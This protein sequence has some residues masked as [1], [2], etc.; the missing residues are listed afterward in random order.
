MCLLSR[1]DSFALAIEVE[2]VPPSSSLRSW[3]PV[4]KMGDTREGVTVENERVCE[5]GDC[6]P[7]EGVRGERD[8][9]TSEPP[10]GTGR[11]VDVSCSRRDLFSSM[12]SLFAAW[13][14]LYFAP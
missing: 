9:R 11:G 3:A 6:W 5:R 7:R 12:R 4:G 13:R 14:S 10:R 2:V 1:R 8:D